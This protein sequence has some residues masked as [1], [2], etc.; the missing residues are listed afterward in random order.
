M[1]EETPEQTLRRRYPPG[2]GAIQQLRVKA[3]LAQVRGFEAQ[4][5]ADQLEDQLDA[6]AD[7]VAELE[8]PTPPP[9]PE[10]EPPALMVTDD[11]RTLTAADVAWVVDGWRADGWQT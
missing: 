8:H 2:E 3:A 6:M 9:E 4:R 11:A 1:I 5:R 10:S 7:R